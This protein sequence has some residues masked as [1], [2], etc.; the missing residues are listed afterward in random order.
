MILELKLPVEVILEWH[1]G[2][3]TGDSYSADLGIYIAD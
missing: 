2:V 3:N 1:S